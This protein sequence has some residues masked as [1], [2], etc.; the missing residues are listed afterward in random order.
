[1]DHCMSRSKPYRPLLIVHEPH[2]LRVR[3]FS[4]GTRAESRHAVADVS[5]P[6][7][8]LPHTISTVALWA[9]QGFKAAPCALGCITVFG[10]KMKALALDFRLRSPIVQAG[11]WMKGTDETMAH[12]LSRCTL[13]R[14]L[15]KTMVYLQLSPSKMLETVIRKRR[16]IRQQQ[17]DLGGKL[18]LS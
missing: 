7:L 14:S 15:S 16:Q 9:T 13:S 4:W 6:S 11:P 3:A 12:G 2:T 18:L 5:R 8:P 1:M 17:Q 10:V